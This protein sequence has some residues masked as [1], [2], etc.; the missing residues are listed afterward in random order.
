MGLFKWRKEPKKIVF[1]NK[2]RNTINYVIENLEENEKNCRKEYHEDFFENNIKENLA[3]NRFIE[4]LMLKKEQ[5]EMQ[6][7][8]D[9]N[10]FPQKSN[11]LCLKE[12]M[13]NLNNERNNEY[14]NL[15]L[16]DSGRHIYLSS[17]NSEDYKFY[18]FDY[19]IDEN[20][21]FSNLELE[22]ASNLE[23]S[24]LMMNSKLKNIIV[25][26]PSKF[27]NFGGNISKS[28]S[29]KR[30]EKLSG[31]LS[32][33]NIDISKI[34][35]EENDKELELLFQKI[36]KFMREKYGE[37]KG[38]LEEV[39]LWEENG[40]KNGIRFY[41]KKDNN[42][43][44]YTTIRGIIDIDMN[45]ENELFY[46]SLRKKKIT[47][48]KTN[49]HLN[50]LISSKDLINYI[51]ETD[52]LSYDNTVDKSNRVYTWDDRNPGY[53]IYYHSYKGALGVQG[54]D[55]MLIGYKDVVNNNR[56]QF[57][58]CEIS[59]LATLSSSSP[60]RLNSPNSNS[61]NKRMI[62]NN[63]SPSRLKIWSKKSKKNLNNGKISA[64][65]INSKI[66]DSAFFISS[67]LSKE[68]SDDK[69]FHSL[70]QNIYNPSFVKAKCYLNGVKVEKL[71]INN[72]IILRMDI[73]WIGDLNGKLPEFLKKTLLS[74]SLSTMKVLKD[75]YIE[76]KKN[77]LLNII[78]N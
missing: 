19:N 8:D 63:I 33:S 9:D 12:Y 24:K 43:D 57:S 61:N 78:T 30:S 37:Y 36:K 73:L 55:F 4:D 6:Q 62:I 77:E 72:N 26:F 67:D 11:F 74:S 35:D 25:D 23:F 18:S 15:L 71:P 14:M 48:I 69:K 7:A 5:I 29:S 16:N 60:N 1:Q 58:S 10:F 51:W 50:D 54:R 64:Q 40:N 53:C 46:E 32:L 59:N 66:E 31:S 41:K 17:N 13:V 49:Y 38:L 2:R 52:P 70:I 28:I 68:L 75:K 21:D 45:K 39:S 56:D 27:K 3:I 65:E 22:C 47:N 76:G 34:N 20:K 42:N 44:A